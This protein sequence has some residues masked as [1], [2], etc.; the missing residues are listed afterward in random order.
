MELR[1]GD[2]WEVLDEAIPAGV[3]ELLARDLV[4]VKR[5]H[6][7]LAETRTGRMFWK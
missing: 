6:V 1:L 7:T 4:Q 3:T 5:C 2:R